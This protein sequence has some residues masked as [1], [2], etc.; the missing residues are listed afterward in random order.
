MVRRHRTCDGESLPVDG[1]DVIRR[2]I[3][4]DDLLAGPD[5]RGSER[6]ADGAGAPDQDRDR[7][8]PDS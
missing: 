5:E 7:R 1:G 2:R 8:G 4:E 6:R 3:D